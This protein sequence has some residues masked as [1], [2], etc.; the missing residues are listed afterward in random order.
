[1]PR[2]TSGTDVH[3]YNLL[4]HVVPYFCKLNI[5]PNVITGI[6]IYS[7]VFLINELKTP[8]VQ[9]NN[10]MFHFILHAILD[11]LDGEVARQCSKTSTFG[12]YLDSFNDNIFKA[13]IISYFLKRMTIKHGLLIT[14]SLFLL[15]TMIFMDNSTHQFK[16][17]FVE[18]L[19]DNSLIVLIFTC[20]I[21]FYQ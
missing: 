15:D 19:H 2:P 3:V 4:D 5:H 12:S 21:L 10:I 14:M 8:K 6:S 9:R 18:F 17:K 11:C 16:N 13:I 20:L 1:M 7:K